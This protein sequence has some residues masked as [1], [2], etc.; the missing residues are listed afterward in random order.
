MT[1]LEADLGLRLLDRGPRG[2]ALTAQGVLVAEWA[3]DTLD[4]A[5]RFRSATESL[6]GERASSFTVSSSQ[7]VAEALMPQ[8]LAALRAER[9]D[10]DIR[11]HVGNSVDV[12][13]RVCAGTSDVGFI[14][15]PRARGGLRSVDVTGDS[16][17]IVVAPAHPWADRKRPVT[18]AELARTPLIVRESGSGT[19][20]T[21]DTALNGID[22]AKPALEL[23]S[24]AAVRVSVASGAGVAVLSELAVASAVRAGELVVVPTALELPRRIRA[25]RL[26]GAVRAEAEALV[27]IARRDRR[28]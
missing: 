20:T 19:R 26:P 6:R 12:C 2:S 13:E 17:V 5:R 23:D 1:R 10:L 9:P 21:L 3:A 25:V 28:F 22:R 11:L 15:S 18:A 7:T 16:L 27:A 24:N 4:A 14:E 8:W